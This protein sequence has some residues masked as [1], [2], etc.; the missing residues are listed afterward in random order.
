MPGAAGVVGAARPDHGGDGGGAVP[1]LKARFQGDLQAGGVQPGAVVDVLPAGVGR[2]VAGHE[3]RGGQQVVV[4]ADQHVPAGGRVSDVECADAAAVPGQHHGAHLQVG[5]GRIGGVANDALGVV[6]RTV[7]DDE[8]LNGSLVG[9]GVADEPAA[10]VP[11]A[12]GA[13]QGA[14]AVEQ[15]HHAG[16]VGLDAAQRLEHAGLRADHVGGGAAVQDHEGL[17][18]R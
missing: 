6:D 9:G 12:E 13:A 14:V 16:A 18:P 10:H 11:V 8:H 1:G 3:V 7:D 17:H 2:H 4:T 15:E 5:G